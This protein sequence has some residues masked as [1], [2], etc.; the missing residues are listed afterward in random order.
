MK[1]NNSRHA[2]VRG[3]ASRSGCVKRRL[4]SMF[5][6]VAASV[7]LCAVGA[8][9]QT[10]NWASYC[11]S[12]W[13]RPSDTVGDTYLVTN[14]QQLAQ[15][16][17]RVNQSNQSS[18]FQ[19]KT[20]KL[21][22]DIDL[23]AHYWTPV[24][25]NPPVNWPFIGTFDGNGKT[26]AG[27]KVREVSGSLAYAG[28]FRDL[29]SGLS[30]MPTVRN[31]RFV[32]VDVRAES[33][34][35]IAYAGT[36]AA[37]SGPGVIEDCFVASGTVYA[38]GGTG[39][40]YAGGI[41]GSHENGGIIRNCLNAAA[42]SVDGGYSAWAGGIAAHQRGARILNCQNIG[43]VAAV[44]RG[45]S[46]TFVGGISGGVGSFPSGSGIIQ[47]CFNTGAVVIQGGTD[48]QNMAG[49]LVGNV[50]NGTSA[51]DVLH[52]YWWAG[53]PGTMATGAFGNSSS[54]AA[55]VISVGAAP[56]TAGALS[57]ETALNN[58]VASNGPAVYRTWGVLG[59]N[60]NYGYPVLTGIW[61]MGQ[62]ALTVSAGPGGSAG[63]GGNYAAGASV[64]VTASPDAGYSFANWTVGGSVVSAS[65]P[66]AFTMPAAPTVITANFTGNVYTVTFDYDNANSNGNPASKTVTFGA[67]YGWLPNPGK[68]GHAFGGWYLDAAFTQPVG[69]AT[70]VATA[71][72]HTL[73]ARWTAYVPPTIILND[74]LRPDD[75][76][77]QLGT[78]I[79]TPVS[80]GGYAGDTLPEDG[81]M[82]VLFKIY[83]HG[84]H[85]LYVPPF[86]GHIH[87]EGSATAYQIIVDDP[88]PI[89]PP[90]GWDLAIVQDVD[91]PVMRG[92][93]FTFAFSVPYAAIVLRAAVSAEETDPIIGTYIPAP[94]Y[95]FGDIT[96][97]EVEITATL[98]GSASALSG[99]ID[100]DGNVHLSGA[101][102]ATLVGQTFEVIAKAFGIFADGNRYLVAFNTQGTTG[103]GVDI[104]PETSGLRITAIK[105]YTDALNAEWVEIEAEGCTH[106]G[107]GYAL[108]GDATLR[109]KRDPANLEIGFLPLGARDDLR[110][111]PSK[112]EITDPGFTGGLRGFNPTGG[113][114]F[115]FHKRL[116]DQHF[117]HLRELP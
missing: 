63:G 100:A 20:V 55:S 32:G 51:T 42:V 88:W 13:P 1:G 94:G 21:M 47:N 4:G 76:T 52:S 45:S 71:S 66:F 8:R 99:F 92:R 49:A 56:G 11:D 89:I 64:P 68:T 58:W 40:A 36:V 54:V 107:K 75:G 103:D 22:A 70:P 84:T 62:Y 110:Y 10:G 105:V 14:A 74:P 35:G 41:V 9:G 111:Y 26:I 33:S 106:Y 59:P 25:V 91:D 19:G 50:Q 2:A 86:R 23:S 30:A 60:V 78:Y 90:G 61:T 3:I 27:M 104:L 93:E 101:V 80:E 85:N 67:A 34:G 15:F 7:V 5:G 72:D 81:D 109:A 31:V 65:N 57:L 112:G 39:T 44:A 113:H 38:K 98:G 24:G 17:W 48:Y 115:K 73:Y 37:V 12:G 87:R 28:F 82:P 114:T 83:H 53:V 16:A 18:M 116:E 6:P 102:D 108:F 79:P 29:S 95:D 46:G 43:T 77:N 69:T 117:F 96:A 97:F